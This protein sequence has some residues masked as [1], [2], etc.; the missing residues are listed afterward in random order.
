[1]TAV[2]AL[3]V[4]VGWRLRR[5]RAYGSAVPMKG[6]F[7]VVVE[8]RGDGNDR[9]AGLLAEL[10]PVPVL[11]RYHFHEGE[12]RR[13]RATELARRFHEAGH[14]VSIALVQS[15]RAVRDPA[16]WETFCAR[17]VEE[18]ADFVDLVEVGHAVNRVKWG[19]WTLRDVR[20][21]ARPFRAL[22]RRFPG[23]RLIGPAVNDFEYHWIL[24]ASAQLPFGLRWPGGGTELWPYV[25]NVADAFLLIGIGMILL[26]LWRADR[27]REKTT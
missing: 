26:R 15:R 12:K 21:L 6:R 24:A 3:P 14:A 19:T 1:V 2:A 22:R 5:R 4:W 8:P 25:S 11:V 7:G 20:R 9:F 16:A 17:S 10:G 18:V 27:P 23:L 13:R